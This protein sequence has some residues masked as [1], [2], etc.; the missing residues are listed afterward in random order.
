MFQIIDDGA[1]YVPKRERWEVLS[2]LLGGGTLFVM[3][4]NKVDAHF[5]RPYSNRSVDPELERRGRDS[6]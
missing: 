4:Q 5:R 1:I 6:R 2:D 3:L